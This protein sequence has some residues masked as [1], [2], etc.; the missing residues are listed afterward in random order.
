MAKEQKT[1]KCTISN[2]A[3]KEFSCGNED[4]R[5]KKKKIQNKSGTI[6]GFFKK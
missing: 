1:A 3:H 4:Y 2:C 5:K 6:E